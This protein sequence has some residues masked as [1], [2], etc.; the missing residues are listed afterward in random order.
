[1]KVFY[2]HGKKWTLYCVSKQIDCHDFNSSIERAGRNLVF[3]LTVQQLYE[4]ANANVKRQFK[5]QQVRVRRE[6]SYRLKIIPLVSA[7]SM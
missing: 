6:T 7:M 4:T 1:M 3:S 2:Q 5:K